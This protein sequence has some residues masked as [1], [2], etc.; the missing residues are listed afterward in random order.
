[1]PPASTLL[2]LLRQ[3]AEGYRDKVAFSFSYNGDEE[4]RT[5]LTYHELDIKARAIA[6]SLQQQGAAGERV[7]VL[8]GRVWTM[9]PV[10]SA[11]CT[12][13]WPSCE[14]T[15]CR[16]PATGRWVPRTLLM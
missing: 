8:C 6:S 14:Q 7:L 1:M 12:G 15:G 3:R 10:S 16:R 2:D 11:V 9:S 5:Q 4:H 13:M